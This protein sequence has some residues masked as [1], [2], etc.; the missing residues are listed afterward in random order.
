MKRERRKVFPSTLDIAK[1]ER[2]EV[3]LSTVC[4][5]K[6]ERRKVF[7]SAVDVR[8]PAGAELLAL[9]TKITQDGVLSREGVEE[10][11]SW[12]DMNWT[13]ELPA[14]QFLK[15]V[16]QRILADSKITREERKEL[17]RALETVLPPDIRKMA[18]QERRAVEGHVKAQKEAEKQR[19]R[20]EAER[21]RPLYHGDFVVAATGEG[22]RN[23]IVREYV[24]EDEI[25]YLAR[26]RNS[27]SD[28]EAVEVRL[29]NGFQIGYVPEDEASQIAPLLDQGYPHAAFVKRILPG[30]GVPVV[31]ADI[32][33]PE[34]QIEYA[35]YESD[36]PP[37]RVYDPLHGAKIEEDRLTAALSGAVAE[38]SGPG[39][40]SVDVVGEASYQS[41]L[42]S[43]C[44]GR[45]EDSQRKFVRA[46]LIYEN[47]NPYDSKAVRVDIKG[48]AVGHLS[49]KN[50]RE[51]RKV[52]TAAGY[53]GLIATCPAVIVG[54]WDRSGEDTGYF[55]VKL[56]LATE[57]PPS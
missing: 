14:A 25:V 27:T 6:R 19:K 31:I 24:S 56:D 54:G 39:T 17:H 22:W 52:M 20:E 55:G 32:Y 57:T 12:I 9:C 45:S 48:K 26:N 23:E 47:K 7:L 50:A 3:F 40:Y 29:Y 33:R 16:L 38:I 42:E 18:K 5:V 11:R 35:S 21:V 4:V 13:A 46:A 30:G 36:V 41:A 37:K 53:R 44:G 1:R 34:A 2:R 43:L 28:R 51:Y 10:L 8:S 15:S 49:R